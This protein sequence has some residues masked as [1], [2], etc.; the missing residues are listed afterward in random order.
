MKGNVEGGKE[1]VGVEGAGWSC[2]YLVLV[3]FHLGQGYCFCGF[4][5]CDLAGRRAR[6]V[7]WQAKA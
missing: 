1:G 5:V 2:S 7:R 4:V 6:A 3:H